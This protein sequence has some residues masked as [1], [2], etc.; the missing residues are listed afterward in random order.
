VRYNGYWE[1]DVAARGLYRF[2]LRRWPREANLPLSGSIPGAL[3][4]YGDIRFGTGY[5]GGAAIDVTAAVVSVG[6]REQRREVVKSDVSARFE[7]DLDPG[8]A[9]LQTCWETADGSDVGAYYVYLS[10]VD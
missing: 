3:C 7:L 8:P 4:P 9:H 2:E 5:G 10:K 6:G 1:L